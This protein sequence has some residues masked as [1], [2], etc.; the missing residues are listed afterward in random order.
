MTVPSV[1]MTLMAEINL[2]GRAEA[3]EEAYCDEET[4]QT[5]AK[6]PKLGLVEATSGCLT[7]ATD[8]D[9]TVA[10]REEELNVIAECKK[11]LQEPTAGADAQTYSFPPMSGNVDL[12]R[13]ETTVLVKNLAKSHYSPTL[14]QLAFRIGVVM[15]YGGADQGVF[16]K[17]KSFITGMI[18]NFGKEAEKGHRRKGILQQG[19][20][21][22][23]G[24]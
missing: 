6:N 5:E 12:R 20:C 19:N 9:V 14:A 15:Q 24:K 7:V 11:I 18:P 4:D 23:R 10:S 16:N 22:N 17:V 3:A 13:G 21:Q 8:H 1:V 2:L